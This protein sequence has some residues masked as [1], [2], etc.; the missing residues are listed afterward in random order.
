[1]PEFGYPN[2]EPWV[3]SIG[4]TELFDPTY[5]PIVIIDASAEDI[6]SLGNGNYMSFKSISFI[7]KENVFTFNV[8]NNIYIFLYNK[9]K[10]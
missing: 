1:M 7:L 6:V 10:Y 4:R 3:R 9:I 2:A 5:V 8:S